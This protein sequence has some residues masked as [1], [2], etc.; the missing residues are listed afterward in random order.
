MFPVGHIDKAE[1]RRLA[2]E[3]GLRTAAKPDSQD[4]CF[5]TSTGGRETFLGDRIPF[6]PGRVV[7][8]T[9]NAVGRVDAVEMVTI[10]QRRG[11][12]LPGGGPKRYVVDVDVPNAVVTV[13]GDDDLYDGALRSTS[14][15]WTDRPVAGDV[16][17]QCS[18]HGAARR[19]R[20][21]P[22][23]ATVVIE[24]ARPQRRVAPGQSV[25]FYDLGDRRVLGGAVASR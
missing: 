10:G 21:R 12:G 16:L 4:V 18:A 20:I 7:D 19:A 3:I 17:V 14:P 25:V 8:A 5:I 11:L 22:E 23:A 1:V 15:V 9:G 6:R 24:W 2:A 13:G